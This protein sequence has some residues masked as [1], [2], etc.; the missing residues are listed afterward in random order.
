MTPLERAARALCAL[1]D[2]TMDKRPL[3]QDY[4]PEAR[5]VLTAIRHP[6]DLM[7]EAAGIDNDWLV[8]NKADARRNLWRHMIDI[9]LEEKL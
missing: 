9:A 2:A 7:V 5:A 3:W 1:A 8:E 6:S 4:L